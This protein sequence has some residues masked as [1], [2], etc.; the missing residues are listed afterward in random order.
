MRL[1]CPAGRKRKSYRPCSQEIHRMLQEKLSGRVLVLGTE[2]FMYPALLAA[3]SL[4]GPGVKT[5]FHATTRSPI[6]V[7]REACYPL[8]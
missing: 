2:E 1:S 6:A 8:H 4:S 5:W 7:F 3:Q